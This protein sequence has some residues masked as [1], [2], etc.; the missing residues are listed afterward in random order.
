[1]VEPGALSS[2]SGDGEENDISKGF[3]AIPVQL[4]NSVRMMNSFQVSVLM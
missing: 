2:V 3:E 1:M 4:Q